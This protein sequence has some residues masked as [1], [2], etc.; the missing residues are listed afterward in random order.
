MCEGQNS[1]FFRVPIIISLFI[2]NNPSRFSLLHTQLLELKYPKKSTND[3][4]SSSHYAMFDSQSS[5]LTFWCFYVS[6]SHS[7]WSL[8]FAFFLESLK[9]I[10]S[11]TWRTINHQLDISFSV[12][13]LLLVLCVRESSSSISPLPNSSNIFYLTVVQRFAGYMR[14][15]L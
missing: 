2:W 10:N 4:D 5:F 6:L 13:L 9:S 8:T 14:N 15:T 1:S 3:R 12:S 11:T 7:A